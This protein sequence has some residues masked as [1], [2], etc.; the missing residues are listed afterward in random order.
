MHGRSAD[1]K[2]VFL[3][4]RRFGIKAVEV[5]FSREKIRSLRFLQNQKKLNLWVFI[6]FAIPGTPKDLLCYFV[7]L[8]EMRFANWMLIISVARIPSVITSTIGGNALG[9]KN[10]LFAII[11]F[12]ATMLLSAAGILIYRIICKR[13]EGKAH[14]HSSDD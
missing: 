5:F 2:L 11:V 12:A 6:I 10:Y 9:M 14:E 4:V 1:R 8:T 7:G 13:H 3:F